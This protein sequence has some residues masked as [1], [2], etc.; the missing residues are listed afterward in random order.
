M[1]KEI[2]DILEK[3]VSRKRFNGKLMYDKI[4]SI[5]RNDTEV[6]KVLRSIK[7]KLGSQLYEYVMKALLRNVFLI[8]LVNDDISST[9]VTTRWVKKKARGKKQ[10][11]FDESDPRFCSF[12]N[13]FD[14]FLNLLHELDE[15]TNH[16]KNIDFLKLYKEYN[17]LSY[18]LPIDYIK[19]PHK[20]DLFYVHR[21]DNITWY[22][23]KEYRKLMMLRKFLL[24]SKTNKYSG[25]FKSI[26]KDKIMVKT[27]LTDRVQTGPY[28]TDREKRWEAHPESVHFSL[29]KTCQKIE[30]T[31]LNQL[32]HFE[33]FP[34]EIKSKLI[35]AKLIE[36]K[37]IIFRCPITLDI[38]SFSELKAEIE[39]KVHGKSSFQIGH[40]N[41]LKSISQ[42]STKGHDPKNISWISADGNRIQGNLSLEETRTLLR[43][44]QENYEKYGDYQIEIFII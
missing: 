15:D 26:I 36:E 3:I 37:G 20:N 25:L 7:Y 5:L 24:D 38:L 9:K 27:Y 11:P 12:K 17:I 23:G 40:L 33:G 2:K 13:C 41:P 16:H 43:R 6:S 21:L 8:E 34:P 22:W 29:R 31:L 39:N 4:E 42:G 32:C 44:I 19:I 28:K 1:K 35:E 10:E 30:Y 18:E 14:I